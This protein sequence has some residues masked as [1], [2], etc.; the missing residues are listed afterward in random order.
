MRKKLVV[1]GGG[2]S[3]HSLIPFLKDS[4][5]DVSVYTSKPEKWNKTIEV[6]YQDVSGNVLNCFS[7][8][9]VCASS[10]PKEIVPTAD[11]IVLCMPVHKYRVALHEIAPFIDKN[12]TVCIGTLYGQGGFNWMVDEIK[13][14]MV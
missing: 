5:F 12:K 14:N 4:V 1:C 2:S 10:K 8:N 7:G 3:A 6:E 11:Y 9:I 13:K